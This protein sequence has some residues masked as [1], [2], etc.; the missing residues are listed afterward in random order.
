MVR[1]FC[2]DLCPVTVSIIR[3]SDLII[4]IGDKYVCAACGYQAGDS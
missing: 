2:I 1:S 4:D 3:K